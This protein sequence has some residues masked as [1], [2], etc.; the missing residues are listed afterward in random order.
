MTQLSLTNFLNIEGSIEHE[1]PKS[2]GITKSHLFVAASGAACITSSDEEINSD[3]A[4]LIF[5]A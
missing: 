3:Q 1:D 4:D 2:Q 5:S